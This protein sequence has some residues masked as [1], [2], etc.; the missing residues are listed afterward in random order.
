[1][2]SKNNNFSKVLKLRTIHMHIN[3]YIGDDTVAK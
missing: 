3:Q 2:S 1:M